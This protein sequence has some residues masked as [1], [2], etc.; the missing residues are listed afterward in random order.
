MKAMN[1]KINTLK[2]RLENFRDRVQSGEKKSNK[3][4]KM[5]KV[6]V[7]TLSFYGAFD[8]G[9]VLFFCFLPKLF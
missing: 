6:F 5:A 9:W 8:D 7:K 1:E 2:E 3:W 4:K